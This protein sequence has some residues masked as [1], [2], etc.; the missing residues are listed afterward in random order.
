MP[1]W[2]LHSR[3]FKS[4]LKDLRRL[5]DHMDHICWGA[6]NLLKESL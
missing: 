4:A 2:I 1:P 6:P 5:L 3:N